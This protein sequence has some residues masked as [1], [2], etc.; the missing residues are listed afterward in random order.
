MNNDNFVEWLIRCWQRWQNRRA[1][2]RIGN[3]YLWLCVQVMDGAN[4]SDALDILICALRVL[5][6]EYAEI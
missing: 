1:H 3:A 4:E 6:K 2:K 5:D